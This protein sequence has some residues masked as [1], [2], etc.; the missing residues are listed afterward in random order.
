MLFFC[1]LKC[2][3]LLLQYLELR[4]NRPI[5]LLGSLTFI[6][7]MVLYMAV[8]MYAPALAL[9]QGTDML[10]F[11]FVTVWVT[12]APPN[13][14]C[15]CVCLSVCLSHLSSLYFGYY[16]SNFYE[17]WRKCWK[18]G[19]LIVYMGLVMASLWHRS[20]DLLQRNLILLRRERTLPR[21]WHKKQR[22]CLLLFSVHIVLT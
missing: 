13:Y 2:S 6:L 22:Y 11:I 16:G 15:L 14:I 19:P 21:L 10:E 8:V 7:E 18:F 9:S 1:Y 17:T 20:F 12:M 5:P 3:H 4:F